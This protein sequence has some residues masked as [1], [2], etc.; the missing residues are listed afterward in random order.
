MKH[1][2]SKKNKST[3]SNNKKDKNKRNKKS[4]NKKKIESEM[5]HNS[6]VI[7]KR[8]RNKSITKDKNNKSVSDQDKNHKNHIKR[9]RINMIDIEIDH[10]LMNKNV[11]EEDI[12][13]FLSQDDIFEIIYKFFLE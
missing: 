13:H 10:A 9:N 3:N 4:T 7:K 1:K 5:V 11:K 2:N 8:K 12:R 6:Q